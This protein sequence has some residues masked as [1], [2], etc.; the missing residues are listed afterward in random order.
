MYRY[1]TFAEKLNNSIGEY[2]A[3]GIAIL[4][5]TGENMR[6]I[7]RV[8][9]IS[10]DKTVVENLAEMCNKR[11]LSPCHIYDVIEDSLYS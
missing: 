8:S 4:E 2:T 10:A 7:W 5:G 1:Q 11:Q 9:D 3:F 6:E